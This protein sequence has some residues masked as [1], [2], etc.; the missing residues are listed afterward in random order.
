MAFEL[1]A[2][3]NRLPDEHRALGRGMQG[4]YKDYLRRGG[5]PETFLAFMESE[6]FRDASVALLDAQKAIDSALS[7]GMTHEQL[8]SVLAACQGGCDPDNIRQVDVLGEIFSVS[9]EGSLGIDVFRQV[10]ELD[11]A[12]RVVMSSLPVDEAVIGDAMLALGAVAAGPV[13]LGAEVLKSTLVG[14]Y[15]DDASRAA[16]DYVSTAM[17]GAAHNADRE[18]MAHVAGAEAG[19]YEALFDFTESLEGPVSS[20]SEEDKALYDS[21]NQS[22]ALSE[23][24]GDTLHG[25]QI[26]TDYVYAVMVGA[27]G[28]VAKSS[29]G[30]HKSE[31]GQRDH[32]ALAIDP[33][34][35]GQFVQGGVQ[36][37]KA[38]GDAFEAKIK[39]QLEKTD[40]EVVQQ[41]TI[42][43]QSGTRTRVDFLSRDSA[44]AIKCTECKAS[45]TARLTKNQKKAFP[46]IEQSGGVVV[47]KGKPGFPGGTEIPPMNVDIVRP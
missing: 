32:E 6:S 29:S 5:N 45:D 35:E 9:D 15:I 36:A 37:N 7:K 11:T 4:A 12:M 22:I 39:I 44:G 17:A 41:V 47:G 42:K 30:D 1:Y 27:G 14:D 34:P 23:G 26:V 2:L 46:E 3:Q 31:G 43:T 38:A 19:L 16:K 18:S 10:A 40:P 20:Y 13:R 21:L 28:G 24:F 8:L 33:Q 25:A